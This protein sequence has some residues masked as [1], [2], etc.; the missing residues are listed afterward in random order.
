MSRALPFFLFYLLLFTMLSLGD[1]MS[2]TLFVKR[3]GADQLPNYYWITALLNFALMLIYMALAGVWSNA[4]LFHWIVFGSVFSFLVAWITVMLYPNDVRAFGLFFI[5][6]E[7]SFTL[8]T[9]HLGNFVQDYFSRSD[10]NRILPFIFSGGRLGGIIGGSLLALL[11]RC[12]PVLNL[13]WVYMGLGALA[14]AVLVFIQQSHVLHTEASLSLQSNTA[15]TNAAQN[16]RPERLTATTLPNRYLDIIRLL[17]SSALLQWLTVT[18]LFFIVCRWVLNYQY[19]HFFEAHFANENQLAEFMGW[20]TS[21]ALTVA[22]V[23]QLTLVNRMVRYLGLSL[24]HAVY[25][26]VLVLTMGM[27]VFPMTLNG[28]LFSRFVETEL[29]NG[30]RNPIMMLMTNTFDRVMRPQARAWLMGVIIPIATLFSSLL[31]QGGYPV[32]WLGLTMGVGYVFAGVGIYFWLPESPSPVWE[33]VTQ[34][35]PL[36]KKLKAET[37]RNRS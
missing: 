30:L 32:G 20:Y 21:I 31:L 2:I 35:M 5:S 19:S 9:M 3:V 7:L 11:S 14:W 1:G 4:K 22:L 26:L 16:A 13:V 33:W 24:T 23:I 27:N 15:Q 37:L 8:V 34:K 36:L 10:L 12:F 28:A 17:K 29:R 6:R 18:S 25:S